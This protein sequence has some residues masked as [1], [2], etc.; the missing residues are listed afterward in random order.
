MTMHDL[1]EELKARPTS[2]DRDEQRKEWLDAVEK[3]FADIEGW[4]TPA[5]AAGGG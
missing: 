3:L 2:L 1:I 5:V 4:L